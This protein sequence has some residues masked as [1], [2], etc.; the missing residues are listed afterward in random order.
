M[1][2]GI[3][4]LTSIILILTAFASCT[5]DDQDP[6]PLDGLT[7]LTEGYAS[8]ASTK[9]EIWGT[10]N[11]FAGY[12]NLT[13]VLY[14]SLD[15]TKKI[16]D[17]SITFYPEMTMTSYVH[18]APFENPEEKAVNGVFPGVVMFNMPTAADGTW[19]LK[20]TVENHSNNKTGMAQ[21][22]VTVDN[23]ANPVMKSFTTFMPDSNKI[24]VSLLQPL[25]PKVGINDIEF[26]VHRKATMMSF[27]A[28]DSYTLEIT[29]EMPTM[30]HG[31]PNNVNPVSAGKGHYK[32][33]VNFTMTG[34]WKINVAVKK[35]GSLVYNTLF[36]YITF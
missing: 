1:K 19:K 32:G 27:P 11:F 22:S 12:N 14:D 34:E 6:S 4:L 35:N 17:A 2:S 28:D 5:K 8:G 3:K 26:T 15:L 24:F 7:K 29:P 10:Q 33:K 16:T 36:F 13:V 30:G 25:S 21:F 18:S 20:V 31:S 23:P 9:V